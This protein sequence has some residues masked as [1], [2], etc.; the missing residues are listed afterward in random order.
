MP[1]NSRDHVAEV[2]DDQAD[3]HEKRDAE[4]ELLANQIAQAL[5]GDRAHA[6]AHFLHHDQRH[7]DGDHGPEQHVSELRAGGGIG[8]DAAGIVVD[9]RGDET[10]TDDGEERSADPDFPTFQ[11]FHA[12][13]AR[14]A[15]DQHKWIG[16]IWIGEIGDTVVGRWPLAK[17][18]YCG[19]RAKGQGPTTKDRLLQLGAQQADDVVGGDDSGQ[20]LVVIDHRQGRAG[21]TCR[22]VPRLLSPWQPSWLEIS[23][24][25]VSESMGVSGV[26]STI[27]ASGTAPA[28]VPCE[29][30][31]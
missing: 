12:T 17:P 18:Q 14:Q 28:R 13:Q 8:P 21:C 16:E 4:S 20:F 11:E 26:A 1:A 31:R 5:A 22:T 30:T 15:T 29:S 6:G 10:R 9:V 3:H 2:D 23:G 19:L 27:L 25:W 7:G 24:S